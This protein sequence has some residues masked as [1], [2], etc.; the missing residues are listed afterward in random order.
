M[1]K[2]GARL[3]HNSI[4]FRTLTTGPDTSGDSGKRTYSPG[5]P[6]VCSVQQAKTSR[7]V[8]DGQ[9]VASVTHTVY[10]P[11]APLDTSTGARAPGSCRVEDLFVWGSSPARTLY[12]LGPARDEAG[13]GE[14]WGVDC[15]E[16]T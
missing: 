14:L 5:T 3:F 1:R 12:A 9:V 8:V 11:A 2:P 13:R 4:T 16:R 15:E 6:L 10:F 7:L